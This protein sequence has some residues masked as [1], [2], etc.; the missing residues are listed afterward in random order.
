[1][2]VLCYLS[3]DRELAPIPFDETDRQLNL[4][5]NETRPACLTRRYVYYCGSQERCGCGFLKAELPEPLWKQTWKELRSGALSPET[6]FGWYEKHFMAPG[7]LTELEE[8]AGEYR[9]ACR[10][11]RQ[12]VDLICETSEMGFDCELLICWAG[13]ENLT[14]DYTYNLELH[15]NELRFNFDTQ[16]FDDES[17][18]QNNDCVRLYRIG[19][20]L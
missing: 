16:D 12:L 14:P 9:L 17:N 13:D 19:A 4:E 7:S 20:V 1:M 8:E 5:V 2:C 3:T 6:A 18:G 10:A 15:R 11:Y